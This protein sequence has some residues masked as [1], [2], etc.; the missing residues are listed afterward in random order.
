MMDYGKYKYE[1]S[2]KAR[3]AR[4]KQS[5]TV[6]K[7]V[8]FRPKIS[9]NDFDVKRK[10]VDRFLDEGD[11]V[12]VTMRFRGR[13][14]THPEI[15]REILDRLVDQVAER[16]VVES[17]PKFEGR[18][19]VMVIAPVRR[20]PRSQ[21]E[22]AESGSAESAQ[23]ADTATQPAGDAAPAAAAAA[24]EAAPAQENPAQEGQAPQDQAQENTENTTTDTEG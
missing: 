16:G 7:E 19:M 20:R 22:P 6:I 8:Q 24:D 10:R 4:K 1:Q 18:Q 9:D 13:E 2:V 11:K 12:K 3:E 21:E 15:G 5:R 23:P 17:P 14:V